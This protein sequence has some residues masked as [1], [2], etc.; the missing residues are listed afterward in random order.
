MSR[1]IAV[2]AFAELD[3]AAQRRHLAGCDSSEAE[4]LRLG[5]EAEQSVGADPAAAAAWLAQL[6]HLAGSLA[7][8]SAAARA[9]RGEVLAIAYLGR[10]EEATALARQARGEAV[11]AGAT[12]EAARLRLA[13]MQPLLKAGQVDEAIAEGRAASR[14]LSDAGEAR[15]AA[16]AEINLGNVF[17]AAGRHDEALAHLDAAFAVLSDEPALAA[18]IENTRGEVLLQIDRFSDARQALARAI[19]HFESIDHRF[20]WSVAEGNLADLAAR[21]GSLAEAFERFAAAR[22]RMPA[23]AEGH[24]ARLL[25]EEGEVFE[26]AGLVEVAL[27]RFADARQRLDRLGLVFEAARAARA[28]A[29]ACL[30][31]GRD[32]EA[33]ASLAL[34]AAGIAAVEASSVAIEAVARAGVAARSIAEPDRAAATD[35]VIRCERAIEQAA[36]R[37]E[38]LLATHLLAIALERLGRSSEALDA[39]R[40]ASA[41]AE[42]LSLA[43]AVAAC[44]SLRA[45]LAR[46]ARRFDEAVAAANAAVAAVERTRSTFGADRLRSAFLGAR[47]DA[48]E[49]LVLSLLEAGGGASAEAAFEVAELARSRTL[50]ER[51]FGAMASTLDESAEDPE[52]VRLRERLQGLHARLASIARDDARS[53]AAD[54]LRLE[55]VR[56]ESDLERRLAERSGHVSRPGGEAAESTD[57]QRWRDVLADDQAIVEYF[58]ASGRMLAFVARRDSVQVAMLPAGRAEIDGTIAKLHFRIR[59]ALRGGERPAGTDAAPL[60]E[61][62]AAWLWAP[63]REAIGTATRL[64]VVPHGS[65]HAVP[66]A[67]V[68]ATAGDRPTSISIVPSASAWAR[69]AGHRAEPDA[70]PGEVLL[71]GV[72]D[73]AAPRIDQEIEA[74]ASALEGRRKIRVLRGEQATASAVVEAL[75]DPAVE[76]AHLAC[77][78]QFLP[79][80]PHASGLRV[81]DR[82]LSVRELASL[83]RTPE[84]VILSGCDTGSVAVLP[85][86]EILGLPRAFLAGGTRRLLGSLWS[87]GDRDTCE[88]MVDLHRRWSTVDR[89][90]GRPSL[91]AALAHAQR[92]RA[93]AD[94]HPARWASFIAI[95]DAS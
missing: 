5:D 52:V 30:A 9:A 47:L 21:T 67:A 69:L 18:T 45:R 93:S 55:L 76:L 53:V 17:K 50:L 22:D 73:A 1:T 79:E 70:P 89:R 35:A 12:V 48:Y 86:E 80:A 42:S 74:V 34:A 31:V 56:A 11:A 39:A 46:Q 43:T 20:A 92:T 44:E 40:R 72:A 6:R 90:S 24:A 10:L 14:E 36:S 82:W 29:R 16:R 28:T 88:L 78:G 58:E 94:P 19:A 66:F 13:A 61:R 62:L 57:R 68:S 81:A 41:D 38:A 63:L 23:Q 49:E 85:G 25:L 3:E 75:A 26:A 27:E 65:M 54:P 87:V 32:E 83:P 95:G 8:P 51:L 84:T 64:V 91:A 7:A 33:L 15:L 59:R 2:A 60:L 71:V 37:L 77:H 4:L